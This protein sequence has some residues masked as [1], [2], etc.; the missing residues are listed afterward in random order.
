[1]TIDS[2]TFLVPDQPEI[3]IKHIK[4]S[5]TQHILTSLTHLFHLTLSQ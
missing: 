5:Q 2:H 3:I 4:Q 1:M